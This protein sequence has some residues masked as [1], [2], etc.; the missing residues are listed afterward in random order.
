M[1]ESAK[2]ILHEKPAGILLS[3]KSREKK[4]ASVLA[5]ENDCTYTHVLKIV[6]DLE[7]RGI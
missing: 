1:N 2:L 3:L 7:D 4:Y 6:S 5:K